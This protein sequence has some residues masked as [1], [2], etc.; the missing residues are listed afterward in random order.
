MK[1]KITVTTPLGFCE[2]KWMDED[3]VD[4]NIMSGTLIS[5]QFETEDEGVVVLR[6]TILKNSIMK[7]LTKEEDL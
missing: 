7:I 5:L 1:V 3:K 2:S 4:A 6:E